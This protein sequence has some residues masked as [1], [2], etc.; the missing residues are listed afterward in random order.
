[1]SVEYDRY[2]EEHK[3]N[4]RRGFYW[5]KHN[6]PELIGFS[7]EMEYAIC[8]CHDK[9]KSDPEEYISYDEY[10]YGGNRSYSVVNDFN[11]AWLRHIHLNDHHWQHWVLI[12]DDPELSEIILDMPYSCILEMICDWWSFSWKTGDLY[13]IFYWYEREKDYIK[14][15]DNTR[16]MVEDI[17]NKI[18]AKLEEE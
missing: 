7:S 6:L 11:R 10:F 5:I 8:E 3:E 4:V 1:M 12:N 18:K 13:E 15:S 2:L 14:L 9:S 17:L 16:K